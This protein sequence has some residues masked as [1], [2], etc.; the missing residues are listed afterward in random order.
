MD[1]RTVLE[2]YRKNGVLSNDEV[3]QRLVAYQGT[4]EEE[5]FRKQIR[6]AQQTLKKKR[7]LHRIGTGLWESS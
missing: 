5:T 3:Y 6:G 2:V 1:S 7:L 4:L